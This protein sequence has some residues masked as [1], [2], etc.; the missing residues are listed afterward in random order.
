MAATYERIASVTIN[1][2]T[3]VVTFSSIPSTYTD[4]VLTGGWFRVTTN[5]NNLGMRLNSDTGNNYSANYMEGDGTSVATGGGFGNANYARVAA[6]AGGFTSS[7]TQSL[8]I[9]MQFNDYFNT[10]IRKTIVTRYGQASAVTGISCSVWLSTSA[11]NAIELSA[12]SPGTG[13]FGAGS[14]LTLYGIKAGS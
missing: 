6:I 14:I 9:T 5:G 1:S 2:A 12:Y 13:E 8:P 11:I 4:L 3:S 10:Q 7:A